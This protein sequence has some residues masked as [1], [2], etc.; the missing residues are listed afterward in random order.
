MSNFT[1]VEKNDHLLAL[2]FK[3]LSVGDVGLPEHLKIKI[4]QQAKVQA[5]LNQQ[6]LDRM[7]ARCL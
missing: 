5:Q 4:M 7:F 1:R 2:Q 3:Q 6:R